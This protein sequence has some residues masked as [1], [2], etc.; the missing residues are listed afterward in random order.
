MTRSR[1]LVCLSI[2]CLSTPGLAK[3]RSKKPAAR[4]QAPVTVPSP[5]EPTASAPPPAD[6]PLATAPSLVPTAPPKP[7]VKR[8]TRIMVG[9]LK[10]D[11]AIPEKVGRFVAQALVQELRKLE[12]LQVSSAADIDEMLS[13]EEQKRLVGC[14]DEVCLSEIV[15]AMGVDQL[16]SGS[17]S[18]T[19]TSHVLTLNRLDVGG[20]KT[21]GTVTKQLEK[22]DGEEFLAAIGPA[23]EVLF[24]EIAVKSGAT[25]GVSPE[26][27]RRLNPPPL[28]RWGFWAVAGTSL[29][30]A[31]G[32]TFAA[33]SSKDATNQFN[34]LTQQALTVPVNGQ[35]LL[36]LQQTASSRA[37]LANGLFLASGGLAVTAGV[38]A[39]FTDWSPAPADPAPV[40]PAAVAITPGRDSGAVS[41]LWQLP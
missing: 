15:A 1:S 6:A 34:S 3:R 31:G 32:A 30:V 17:L 40:R 16:V 24:P 23:V 2:L 12:H 11:P 7:A 10:Q 37:G 5:V 33:L 21:L 28:P 39:F 8:F 22:K 19:A 4:R 13:F 9:T 20:A 36:Q 38:M 18:A 26:V 29:A 41:V 27:A 25:R 14:T 35:Q